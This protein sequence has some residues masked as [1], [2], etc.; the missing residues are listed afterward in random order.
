V[1]AGK[2]AESPVDG[3]VGRDGAAATSTG[4]ADPSDVA[5]AG[6]DFVGEI[7]ADTAIGS[8]GEGSVVTAGAGSAGVSINGAFSGTFETTMGLKSAF[9]LGDWE[10]AI[11]SSA[12]V[13]FTE[14]TE[15]E[16]PVDARGLSSLVEAL[17]D[18]RL[19]L[20]PRE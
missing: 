6:I 17:F 20:E 7:G 4:E 14:L 9:T 18:A 2:G 19:V 12:L 5:S 15:F 10:G 3:E 16:F 11:A 13:V 8:A 1:L